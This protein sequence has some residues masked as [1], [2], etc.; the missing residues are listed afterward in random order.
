MKLGSPAIQVL[1]IDGFSRSSVIL[2]AFVFFLR[3]ILVNNTIS[4]WT[5]ARDEVEG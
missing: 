4:K 3:F 5:G 2:Y 1:I